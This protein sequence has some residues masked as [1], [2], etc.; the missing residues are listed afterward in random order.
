[1]KLKKPFCDIWTRCILGKAE[2]EFQNLFE[3]AG[4]PAAWTIMV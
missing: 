1:M 2:K 4:I 3:K